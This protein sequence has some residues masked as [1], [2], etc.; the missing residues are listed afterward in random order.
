MCTTG[1]QCVHLLFLPVPNVHCVIVVRTDTNEFGPIW[2]EAAGRDAPVAIALGEALKLR[3]ISAVPN[4]HI[5]VL[6]RLSGGD[7]TPVR[8]H[9]LDKSGKGHL[10]GTGLIGEYIK[11][12]Y[13]PQSDPLAHSPLIPCTKCHRRAQGRSVASGSP[14]CTQSPP[15]PQNTPPP[16]SPCR[17]HS[18]RWPACRH[19]HT[20]NQA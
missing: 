16:P 18:G 12:D 19:T 20:Q 6:S 2:R 14:C 7:C 8:V 11:T 1:V 13:S 17:T 10:Y 4:D 9:S 15:P 3:A 5:G